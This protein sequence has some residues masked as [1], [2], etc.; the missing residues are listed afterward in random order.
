MEAHDCT[1][2]HFT[3]SLWRSKRSKTRPGSKISANG[4]SHFVSSSWAQQRQR[5]VKKKA[6]LL[7]VKILCNPIELWKEEGRKI[8]RKKERNCMNKLILLDFCSYFLFFFWSMNFIAFLWR[9][10]AINTESHFPSNHRQTKGSTNKS[11]NPMFSLMSPC[12]AMFE[13]KQQPKK[14]NLMLCIWYKS[15]AVFLFFFSNNF[16]TIA[17]NLKHNGQGEHDVV[18][19]CP[20][21]AWKLTTYSKRNVIVLLNVQNA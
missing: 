17:W 12:I 6:L 16:Y 2:P 8:K 5:G 18:Q 11:D 21:I 13:R 7:K 10:S 14:S 4:P 3:F 20:C 1:V 19:S 15:W 9:K